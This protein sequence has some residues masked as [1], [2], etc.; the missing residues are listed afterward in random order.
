[1]RFGEETVEICVEYDVV[2]VGGGPAGLAAALILGRSRKR[3]LL[4]DDG[5]PRNAIAKHVHGLFGRDGVAIDDLRQIARA[6]LKKYSSVEVID[7]RVTAIE[8]SGKGFLVHAAGAHTARVILLACGLRD[9][10]PDIPG[11]APLWGR[12][13]LHCPYCH[14]W[15]CRE[16]RFGFMPRSV[17]EFE[18]PLLLR[19]WSDDVIVF[20]NGM[21]IDRDTRRNYDRAKISVDERRILALRCEGDDL[22]VIQVEGGEVERDILFA[23]AKQQQSPLVKSLG[24]RMYDEN[25]VYVDEH[26]QTSVPGI[27]AAGDLITPIHGATIA[28]AA[29]TAAAYKINT[30]LT[31][32]LV[33]GE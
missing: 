8:R 7:A 26:C 19:G 32:R 10:L 9:E 17:K 28:A 24:L 18:F 16:K 22:R 31:K 12:S 11:L 3:V 1:M 23:T 21:E 25:S 14:A 33:L 6:E 29:G 20:S 13:V 15:E 5:V 4:F 27:Y 30:M 2:I